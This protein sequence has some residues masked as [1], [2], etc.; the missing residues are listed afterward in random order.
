[1][2]LLQ[3]QSQHSSREQSW[4]TRMHDMLGEIHSA[5]MKCETV[6]VFDR[7]KSIC[8]MSNKENFK[9]LKF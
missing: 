1:M 6:S 4:S 7:K 2:K 3:I 8:L 5:N 9:I